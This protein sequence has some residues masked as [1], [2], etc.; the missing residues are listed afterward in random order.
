[1]KTTETKQKEW[2]DFLAKL[3]TTPPE[4][5]SKA[6]RWFLSNEGKNKD[7]IIVDMKSVL[8]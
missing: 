2:Q 6:A 8:K 3:R 4:K 7:G 5:L 1:M